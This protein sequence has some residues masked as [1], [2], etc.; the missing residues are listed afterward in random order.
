MDK[1]IRSEPFHM[2]VRELAASGPEHIPEEFVPA[3]SLVY[4][5]PAT[6]AYNS[7]GALGF[8]VKR[9][10]LVIPE[11][12]MLLVAP[13]CCGRNSTILSSEEGYSRRMFYLRMTETDL[14]TGRH[15]TAI[16]SAVSEICAAAR[17]VPKVVILCITCVD[18]LLGTDLERICRK[19]ES[20][21][22]VRVVPGYMYALTRE[23]RKP[24]MTAIRQSIYSLLEKREK[25]SDMVNLLGFFSPLDNRSELFSLLSAAGIRVVNQISTMETLDSYMTMGSANFN[26]VLDPESRFAAGDLMK[27]IGLPYIELARLYGIDRIRRQYE[28]FAAAIGTTFDLT[29]YYDTARITVRKFCST[30][31]G[32][33]FAVGQMLNARPF[34]LALSLVRYGFRVPYV[35]APPV[36]ED[37]PHIRQLASISPDTAVYSDMSPTMMN[38]EPV[39]RGIDVALGRDIDRFFPSAAH[40]SWNNEDQPFGFSAVTGLFE[41]TERCLVS[42]S[43][44]GTRSCNREPGTGDGTRRRLR[45]ERSV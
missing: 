1:R 41:E 24:P 43:Q 36:E 17:P 10:A 33:S 27:R 14:I 11:S 19:A 13:D 34:E 5:S 21:T 4:S 40:I 37:F 7:P 8:G 31:A 45:Y 6:L 18:A 35:F 2:S 39:T 26:L 29:P 3:C 44:T 25:R 30:H 23:G 38:F 28:L 15:L 16:P 22:A 42:G 9:A 12:V 20:E 32:I